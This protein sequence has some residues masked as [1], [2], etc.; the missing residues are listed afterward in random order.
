[1]SMTSKDKSIMNGIQALKE[2]CER[3]NIPD[4]TYQKSCELLKKVDD[5]GVVKGA[6]LNT[7]CATILFFASLSSN[8][9][10]QL[11][12]ILKATGTGN[13]EV[14]K[15]Y[16]KMKPV[17]PGGMIGQ[18]SISHAEE[19]A[20]K[21]GLNADV[22]E[23]C[24]ATADNISKLEELTGKKPATIAGVAIWMIVCRSP[25]LRQS[26][27]CSMVAKTVDMGEA[28]IKNAYQIVMPLESQILP[29]G[30]ITK[31]R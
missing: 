13:K 23:V 29:V 4:A 18:S 15:C 11:K 14:S 3:L 26:I 28:A 5:A 1:M 21:L 16:K 31:S 10:T 9:K 12:D 17:L 27:D 7:K 19:A 8:S 24:K 20:T 22:V 2:L 30:F 6:R 25:D